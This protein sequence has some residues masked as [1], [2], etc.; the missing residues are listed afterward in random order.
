[1]LVL[2][3]IGK[4]WKQPRCLSAGEWTNKLWYLQTVE[5]YLAL[6]RNELSNHEK[7]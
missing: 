3:I 4:I 7:M 5:Y 1:M 2:L 6:K